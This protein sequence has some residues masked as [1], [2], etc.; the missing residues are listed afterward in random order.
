MLVV[1]ITVFTLVVFAGASII[2]SSLRLG[3]S[4]MPSSRKA[5]RAM[6][7]LMGETQAETGQIVELGSGWGNLLIALAQAYPQREVVG[8]ELSFIPWLTS[9]IFKRLLGLHNLQVHRKN[10]LQA[11][12]TH[13]EVVVCYLFP[14]VMQALEYKLTN[15]V[16]Q[17]RYLIS[18]NFALPSHTPIKTLK[19]N[20][21][22]RS[23]IYLYAF[24]SAVK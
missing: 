23:P 19:I 9:V 10:F 15:Q 6:L 7:E 24:N 22:Y 5:R 14:Q 16:G 2:W 13:A 18:N 8:Y 1:E 17:T 12:L 11:D 3:I 21:F 4:P 20:D